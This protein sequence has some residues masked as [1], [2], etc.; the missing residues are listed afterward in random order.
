MSF[1]G[2]VL[3]LLALLATTTPAATPV[4]PGAAAIPPLVWELVELPS[5]E[6]Q[7]IAIDEPERYTVQFLPEGE[8]A[9]GADC[10]RAT[11]TYTLSDDTLSITIGISTLAL[12]PPDSQAD[13][14]LALLEETSTFAIDPEGMLV[15]TGDQGAMRFRPSLMG[16]VWEWHDFRGGDDSVVA[17]ER[18][19]RYTLTFLPEGK[20][21]IRAD[22]N[23]GIGTYR[24]DGPKLDIVVGGVTKVMCGP[25]SHMDAFLRDIDAVTS[26]VFRDGKLYL[27]LPVDAG[28]LSFEARY[29][30]PVAATPES[31]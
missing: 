17:P 10:N 31:G 2:S 21:A 13:S 18:P 1:T 8:L 4:P 16:V 22:C 5:N 11:G 19:E 25:G 24:V 26:H 27:A 15:L 23:R 30:P 7:P 14:F 6:G 12:C 20:L 28:I 9:I 29:V 3:L